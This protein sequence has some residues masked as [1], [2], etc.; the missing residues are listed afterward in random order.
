MKKGKKFKWGIVVIFII[1]L[2][3][4]VTMIDIQKDIFAKQKEI[5][6]VQAKIVQEQNTSKELNKLKRIL[7]TD[8]YIIK[9]AREELGMV[10]P[11]EKKFIDPNK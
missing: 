4:S 3:F 9:I 2:Y 10:R 7:N 11:G 5:E 8:E 6:D 1:L